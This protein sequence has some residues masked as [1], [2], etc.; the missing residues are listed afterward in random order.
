MCLEEDRGHPGGQRKPPRQRTDGGEPPAN[1]A[2][3]SYPALCCNLHRLDYNLYDG[4]LTFTYIHWFSVS[5]GP[6]PNIYILFFSP[7][8]VIVYHFT[9][10]SVALLIHL[11]LQ[12]ASTLAWIYN[13]APKVHHSLTPHS[14]WWRWATSG[15]P[16]APGQSNGTATRPQPNIHS[17]SDVLLLPNNNKWEK[18]TMLAT[19]RTSETVDV[20]SCCIQGHVTSSP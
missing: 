3:P 19:M 4:L 18:T 9:P 7:T 11:R 2:R 10:E 8:A 17:H 6:G 20:S 16:A 13:V 15:P 1:T 14:Y 12:P 5:V